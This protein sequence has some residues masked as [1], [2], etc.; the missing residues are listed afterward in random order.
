MLIIIIT[1]EA[2]LRFSFS[3]IGISITEG[4]T[5]FVHHTL[6]YLCSELDNALVGQG[7]ECDSAHIAVQ[8]CRTGYVF[9]TWARGGT[10]SLIIMFAQ[11]QE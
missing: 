10:V 8:L 9:G 4:N 11:R 2:N 1:S 6:I 7:A 5:A 3:Q